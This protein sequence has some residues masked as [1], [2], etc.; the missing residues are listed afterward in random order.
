[1]PTARTQSPG[2]G[3]RSTGRACPQEEGRH[4]AESRAPL[5]APGAGSDACRV[6]GFEDS[7]LQKLTCP[8][9]SAVL[10]GH[11]GRVRQRLC[12]GLGVI[13]G[14]RVLETQPQQHQPP[15][16]IRGGRPA[17]GYVGR[18]WPAPPAAAPGSG[19]R[20]VRRGCR[21]QDSTHPW[22]LRSRSR[23]RFWPGLG[24]GFL[25]KMLQE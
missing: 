15:A 19:G 17:R 10:P 18:P 16:P 20:G 2:K 5:P 1:M 6:R 21:L 24:G 13:C 11:P 7:H 12:P 3:R 23:S 14:G 25:H 9:D 8:P 22:P 4:V